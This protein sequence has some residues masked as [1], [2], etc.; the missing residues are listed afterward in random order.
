VSA[1]SARVHPRR[2]AKRVESADQ[3]ATVTH[4][5]EHRRPGPGAASG[6]CQP[7][8]GAT[9]ES[10]SRTRTVPAGLGMRPQRGPSRQRALPA[11]CRLCSDLRRWWACQDLN[12]GPHPHQVSRAQRCADRRFPRSPAS[13]RDEGMRS[14]SPPGAAH[15]RHAAAAGKP[16]HQPVAGKGDG[17]AGGHDSPIER[18]TETM[19]R[20]RAR[21]RLCGWRVW[22]PARPVQR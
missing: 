5:P 17:A 1:S 9:A 20:L 22:W 4:L 10:M 16:C 3:P 18:V 7:A 15:R 21:P 6:N 19:V 11:R 2:T 13:V 14:N 8:A 12:L